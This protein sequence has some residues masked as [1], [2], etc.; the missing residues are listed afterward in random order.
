MS[1]ED[2]FIAVFFLAVMLLGLYVSG[3]VVWAFTLAL[4]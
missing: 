2:L 1:S 3:L 4:N